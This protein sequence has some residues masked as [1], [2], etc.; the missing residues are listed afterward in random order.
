MI[1]DNEKTDESLLEINGETKTQV[2]PQSSTPDH[3][4]VVQEGLTFLTESEPDFEP[5]LPSPTPI[6]TS[7]SLKDDLIQPTTTKV[8]KKKNSKKAS[9][10]NS[11]N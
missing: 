2:T 7:N 3:Y 5:F 8:A 1:A 4:A 9:G 6:P 10:I 11:E